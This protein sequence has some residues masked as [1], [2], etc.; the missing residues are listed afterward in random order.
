MS[1]INNGE[2][3]VEYSVATLPTTRTKGQTTTSG[4]GST[5]TRILTR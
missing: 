3:L 1:K 2:K 5:T 4:A